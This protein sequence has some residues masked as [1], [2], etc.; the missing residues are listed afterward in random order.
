MGLGILQVIFWLDEARIL[1]GGRVRQIPSPCRVG[2]ETGSIAQEDLKSIHCYNVSAGKM[3]RVCFFHSCIPRPSLVLSTP[4]SLG[5]LGGWMKPISH[6]QENGGQRKAFVSKKAP[7]RNSPPIS[8]S[9]WLI[10]EKHTPQFMDFCASVSNT[11]K[12]KGLG[13]FI[14]EISNWET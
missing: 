4:L 8:C 3:I 14:A 13:S 11:G 7:T 5:H 1:G 9:V 6:K 12:C 2:G 10:K